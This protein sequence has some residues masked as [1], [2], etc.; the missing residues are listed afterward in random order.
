[1]LCPLPS[2]DAVKAVDKFQR[3]SRQG[4][5]VRL[6]VDV[7]RERDGAENLGDTRILSYFYIIG[8]AREH[9]EKRPL[10]DNQMNEGTA[11]RQAGV[12]DLPRLRRDDEVLR[13]GAA[14]L[15]DIRSAAR[16]E[17]KF[18]LEDGD[19]AQGRDGTPSDGEFRMIDAGGDKVRQGEHISSIIIRFLINVLRN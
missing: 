8:Q 3:K 15:P 4:D 5:G 2:R 11:V 9:I 19:A 14:L 10:S 7:I 18:Q 17:R 1:M 13:D 6:R 16:F 12:T